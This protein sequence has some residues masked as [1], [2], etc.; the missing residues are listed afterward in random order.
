MN[1]AKMDIGP[2]YRQRWPW[3]LISMPATSVVLGMVL[4]YFAVTTADGLVVDDYYRQGRAI[5][6]TM[7]RSVHAAELGLAADLE[8][9]TDH[10]T[11]R[12]RADEG[13][14]LPAAVLVTIAHPTRSGRDQSIVLVGDNGEFSGALSPL[15]TGRWLVQ[16]EDEARTWRLRSA[17]YL[18]T[19]ARATILPYGS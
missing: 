10:V 11:V 12:L 1:D 15:T 4:L 6:Q 2:W 3:I 5:D 17:I 16:L 14:V 9:R 7:A 13:V 8:F 18:P 19:Q